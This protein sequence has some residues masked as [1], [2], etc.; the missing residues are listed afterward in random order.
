[1]ESMERRLARIEGQLQTSRR[2]GAMLTAVLVLFACAAAAQGP[3]VVLICKSLEVRTDE[4]Q[5]PIRMDRSA[6]T[7]NT[8]IILNGSSLSS[9][10]RQTSKRDS[11]SR[12]RLSSLSWPS[13]PADTPKRPRPKLI[14]SS[15]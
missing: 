10:T 15:I 1:M 8:D 11:P 5:T 14:I 6:I 9:C 12:A 2:W 13:L 7:V 4:G 3:L